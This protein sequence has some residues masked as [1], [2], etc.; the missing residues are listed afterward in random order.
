MGTIHTKHSLNGNAHRPGSAARDGRFFGF[1]Q[2]NGQ[3]AAV[4]GLPP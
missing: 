4:S 3:R 1:W 2:K